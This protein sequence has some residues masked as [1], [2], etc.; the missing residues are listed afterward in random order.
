MIKILASK[1]TLQGAVREAHDYL[2]LRISEDDQ[3]IAVVESAASVQKAVDATRTLN[4]HAKQYNIGISYFF[5][6]INEV[7]QI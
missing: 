7:E 1:C 3:S 6:P 5:K 2:V 4:R